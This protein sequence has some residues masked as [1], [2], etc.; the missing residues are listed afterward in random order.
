MFA[1]A[2]GDAVE[3]TAQHLERVL[4]I[5]DDSDEEEPFEIEQPSTGFGSDPFQKTET[6]GFSLASNIFNQGVHF[7]TP[8]SQ[9]SQHTEGS[10]SG[11]KLKTEDLDE[12]CKKLKEWN[13]SKSNDLVYGVYL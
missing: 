6:G 7:L 10:I 5:F 3:I 8:E 11:A 1:T 2:K 13:T 9:M 12:V 4:K